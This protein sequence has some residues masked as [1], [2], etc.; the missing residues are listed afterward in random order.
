[1]KLWHVLREEFGIDGAR[2]LADRCARLLPPG[3]AGRV[4][5]ALYRRFGARVERGAMVLGAIAFSPSSRLARLSLGVSSFVNTDVFM[6]TGDR[7]TIGNRATIGHHVRLI[8]TDHEIGP[9]ESRAGTACLRPITIGDGAWL[10]AGVTVLPGVTIGA[11]AVVGAG[12]LVT[13]DVP[14]HTLALGVPA[15]VVRDLAHEPL[16]GQ[17][18]KRNLL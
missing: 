13:R 9:P 15:R 7:I 3:G 16:C 8:T 5:A 18:E 14:Q 12:A 10:G 1:M 2:Y 11:G 4:R 17:P 6:D